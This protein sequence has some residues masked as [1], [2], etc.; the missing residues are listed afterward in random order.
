MDVSSGLQQS[1]SVTVY[2]GMKIDT[3]HTMYICFISPAHAHLLF[4]SSACQTCQRTPHIYA[5]E[6]ICSSRCLLFLTSILSV[7][8]M[9]SSTRQHGFTD[10]V[11]QLQPPCLFVRLP[12]VYKHTL[13]PKRNTHTNV[14]ASGGLI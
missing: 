7:K 1:A 11:H 14:P 3:Y 13:T 9:E 4:T 12:L 10:P 5:P 6:K 2:H 8:N